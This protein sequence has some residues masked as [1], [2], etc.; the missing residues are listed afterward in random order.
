MAVVSLGVPVFKGT[1]DDDLERFIDLYI[2]HLHALG[3]NPLDRVANPSGAK[4]AMGILR[5]C[6]QG[7][8]A[9]WFD[10]ELTG[11]NWKIAHIR[12]QG[13]AVMNA[14]RL[15]A[16]PEGAGGPNANTYVPHTTASA[17]S[18]APA[19]VAVTIG[20]AFIPDGRLK[21]GDA[22]WKR[23]GGK[24]TSDDPNPLYNGPNGNGNPIVLPDI[25]PD[26]ALFWLR[27]QYTTVLQEKQ[28]MR[29][30]T[31]TQD[32]LPIR[33]YYDKLVR[34]AHL[35][36]FGDE[37]VKDQ[38]YRG[39]NPDN[40]IEAERI[41]IERPIEE[42][43]D[44]LERVEKRKAEIH[45][46][47]S[48]RKAQEDYYNKP[49]PIKAPPVS[50]Q[51]AVEIKPVT[52]HAITQ[53]MLNKLLQ[54]HTESLTNNFQAQLQALQ[55]T[56]AQPRKKVPPPVP[57]KNHEQLHDFYE[58]QNPFDYEENWQYNRQNLFDEITKND[59]EALEYANIFAKASAKAKK[60]KMERKVNRLA[61]MMGNL[62]LE[63]D[64][65]MPMDVDITDGTILQD[66]DGNEFTV[67]LTR[68]S[69]KK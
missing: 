60:D 1:E 11:K 42:L 51:D 28:R 55:N 23:S 67:Y 68:G 58:S 66:A 18:T 8:A 13:N 50:Q 69:K 32:S 25:L 34:S 52:S 49:V 64:G 63:D 15:L 46:G 30:G 19:N 10:K 65:R 31:L 54:S 9:N 37:I 44:I 39:L 26:Q 61:N 5:G 33:E 3:I 36:G 27:D 24:P 45:L 43:V 4:R 38:F 16:V 48:R 57:P 47:L 7:S 20:G 35:L 21:G 29:F 6:M 53:D 59:R 62:N 22:L 40:I 17:Y 41:G 14:F 12:K 56:I 2:G